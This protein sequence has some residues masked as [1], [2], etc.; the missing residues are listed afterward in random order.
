MKLFAI[1]F[2]LLLA[3]AYA[4]PLPPPDHDTSNAGRHGLHAT[5]GPA[6]P[7]GGTPE[8]AV[9]GLGDPT[10][11]PM[12]NDDITD[13]ATYGLTYAAPRSQPD[14][15]SSDA[16]RHRLEASSPLSQPNY[17]TPDAAV[18]GLGY[19]APFPPPKDDTSDAA[20]HAL[21]YAA[22]LPLPINDDGPVTA[23]RGPTIPDYERDSSL[24]TPNS[25][26]PET[27]D[28]DDWRSI[29]DWET[30]KAATTQEGEKADATQEED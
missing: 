15:E 11:F 4:A 12:S 5:F 18:H 19:P 16:V 28:G 14:D 6:P 8:A 10:P 30:E 25:A 17:D 13:A 23:T 26:T 2:P 22:P 27:I 29:L 9:Q 1:V 3:G 7:K 24:T 20:V 21:A